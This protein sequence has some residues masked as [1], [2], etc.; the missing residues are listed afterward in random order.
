MIETAGVWLSVVLI[1]CVFTYLIHEK[2]VLYR[3]VV[4]VFVGL[5]AGYALLVAFY[6]V[7]WP[8]VFLP[9]MDAI[10]QTLNGRGSD[11]N[12]ESLI[13]VAIVGVLGLLLVFKLMPPGPLSRLGTL[14]VA[15]MVGVGAAVAVGGATLGTLIPQVKATIDPT[16][17]ASQSGPEILMIGV[18]VLF[19]LGFF[20]YGGRVRPGRAA[21][22]PLWSKVVAVGGQVF[23]GITFGVMYAG[24]LAGGI[25]M[26]VYC[27]G[28]I[29][30]AVGAL[31]GG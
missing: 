11:G 8:Q 22:R 29:G 31:V 13:P 10:G 25:A 6:S 9:V 1:L 27:L 7:L 20:W 18:G 17:T 21:E 16:I 3:V 28:L 15:F 26:L 23:I 5:T 19:T 14:A 24:A 30:N 4:S 2:L 12:L